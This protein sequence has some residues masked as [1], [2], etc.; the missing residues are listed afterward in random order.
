MRPAQFVVFAV[1][2]DE[3]DDGIPRA[4]RQRTRRRVVD[5]DI[6]DAGD[7]FAVCKNIIIERKRLRYEDRYTLIIIALNIEEN[8][9]ITFNLL[10]PIGFLLV[11]PF[12]VGSQHFSGILPHLFA[13]LHDG[14]IRE[15]VQDHLNNVAG[16]VDGFL[17]SGIQDVEEKGD[18][19]VGKNGLHGI[20]CF[21]AKLTNASIVGRGKN[22]CYFVHDSNII[23]INPYRMID[24]RIA[25]F[26]ST[27]I[28]VAIF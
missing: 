23:F 18:S 1:F 26:F 20:G 27:F 5:E 15:G 2:H 17:V 28:S 13:L 19:A 7:L 24:S 8:G 4:P 9:L 11:N 14:S 16:S 25:L 6:E 21:L 3:L 12:P 22:I 10:P